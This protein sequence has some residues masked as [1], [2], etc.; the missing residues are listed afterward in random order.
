MLEKGKKIDTVIVFFLDNV[1]LMNEIDWK[2]YQM[3]VTDLRL[4]YLNLIII[5]CIEKQTLFIKPS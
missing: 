4:C 1:S 2:F 3:L 5:M